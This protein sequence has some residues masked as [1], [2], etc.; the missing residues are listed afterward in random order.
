MNAPV[1][2]PPSKCN[3]AMYHSSLPILEI[4][5]GQYLMYYILIIVQP[6]VESTFHRPVPPGFQQ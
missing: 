4:D 3:Q 2:H 6:H 5:G 1:I